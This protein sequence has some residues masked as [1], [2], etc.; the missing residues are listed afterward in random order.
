[1]STPLP[2]ALAEWGLTYGSK[3]SQ[4]T[5]NKKRDIS[6]HTIGISLVCIHCVKQQYYII[7]YYALL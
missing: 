7:F 5:Q 4:E 2:Q 6:I 1:M 3:A